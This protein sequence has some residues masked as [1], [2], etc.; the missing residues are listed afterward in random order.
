MKIGSFCALLLVWTTLAGGLT[1]C[2]DRMGYE[3]SPAGDDGLVPVSI[4]FDFAPELN[5]Y[6]LPQAGLGLASSSPQARLQDGNAAAFEVSL[7]PRLSTRSTAD[8]APDA[9]YNLEIRQYSS[10]GAHLAGAAFPNPVTIG[11]ALEVPLTPSEDCQLV[12]VARGNGTTPAVDALGT[13]TLEQVQDMLVKSSVI[14]AI[15]PSTADAMNA[16][17]YVLH[18]KHVKVVADANNSGKHIIQSPEGAHDVRLRL[19]RLATRLTV[20][21]DYRVA[22]YKLKQLL[23]QSVPM[24]Y[25][26]VDKPEGDGTYPSVVSQ[27][28]ILSVPIA[29]GNAEQ[30][31]YSCW[32]PANVRG[33]SAAATTES[34]RIKA[35]APMGSTYFNFVAVNND[36]AKKKLDYRVYI[37]SGPSTD[38]NVY[39]NK[40][41]DYTVN[42]SHTGIPADDKRVTYI[43]PI[44]ASINNDNLVPTANCF[45]VEPGGAFCFDPFAF[46]Q[47]GAE[48]TNTQMT[49]WY[50]TAGTGIK[51]VKLL[52]QTRENGDVGDP[53]MGIATDSDTDHTNIV[54]IKRTDGSDITA[55]PANDKGQ[56]RIYCRVAA[57]TTG[58]NG[59]IAAYDDVDG[60]GNIVWSWHVWV[61]DYKPDPTGSTQVLEPVNK[62]KLLFSYNN[63]SGVLPMMD[64][65]LGAMAGYVDAAPTTFVEMSKTNGFHY[66]WGRKDPFPSNYTTKEISKI[67]NKNST[68]PPEGMLNRYGADGITYVV[69]DG[70]SGTVSLQNSCRNPLVFYAANKQGPAWTNVANNNF[71]GW[72]ETNKPVWDPCPAGWRVVSRSDLAAVYQNGNGLSNAN[73]KN[74]NTRDKDGGYLLY[75][76]KA[77]GGYASYFRFTGYGRYFDTFEHIGKLCTIW[78]R[79][80]ASSAYYAYA[81]WFNSGKAP[82]EKFEILGKYQSDAHPTRCVQEKAD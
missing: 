58:G 19:K 79:N 31:S 17:P 44:P 4:A 28:T 43:D 18:L 14:N 37:G 56:C 39:R 80:K 69:N 15:D 25:A 45:V 46:Q 71:S 35:N 68:T 33:E 22:G 29:D 26:I 12:I 57:N 3:D 81:G 2:E 24:N 10:A 27:F 64:R 53:V 51:S 36:D 6:D 72:D 7:S 60:K 62:R 41:Y 13:K 9:L 61:T 82:D 73:I 16:M 40:N 65:N 67:S 78:T 50:S 11:T 66:Q 52:W 48:I 23:I 59:V 77:N 75:F 47:N 1:G 76:E 8:S 5:G 21:W 74:Y 70:Q 32:V 20:T 30:G 49:G 38:F 63:T 54:D 42:F 55:A 34:Q